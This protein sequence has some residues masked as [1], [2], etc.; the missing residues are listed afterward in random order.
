MFRVC[1]V[2]GMPCPKIVMSNV[3]LCLEIVLCSVCYVQGLFN[4]RLVIISTKYIHEVSNL[5]STRALQ[6]LSTLS[7]IS[8]AFRSLNKSYS[9]SGAE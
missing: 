4:Q 5:F 3:C 2:L 8:N 6:L 7:R 9:V 1:Y